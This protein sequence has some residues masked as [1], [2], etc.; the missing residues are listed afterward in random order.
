MA[1]LAVQISDFHTLKM[2]EFDLILPINLNHID[3][4]PLL[5]GDKDPKVFSNLFDSLH[6]G[7]VIFH[8]IFVSDLNLVF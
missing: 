6:V 5:L 2:S 8:N 3:N 7:H 4:G 1:N